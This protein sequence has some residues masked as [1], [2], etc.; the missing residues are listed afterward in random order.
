MHHTLQNRTRVK[1]RPTGFAPEKPFPQKEKA[2]T[3]PDSDPVLLG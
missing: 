1:A 3:N 2:E